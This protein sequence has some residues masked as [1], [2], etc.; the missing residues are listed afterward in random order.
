MERKRLSDSSLKPTILIES[1]SRFGATFLSTKYRDHALNGE[2][3]MDKITG[4]IF[5]KRATDGQIISFQQNK[6]LLNDIAFDFSILLMM[7]PS[8]SYPDARDSVEYN[9][10]SFY[11]STNYDLVTINNEKVFNL[12]NEDIIIPGGPTSYNKL[13]FDVSGKSNGFICKCSTRDC[14]KAF[15]EFITNQ[16]NKLVKDYSGV[17]EIYK[18][19]KSRY[20]DSDIWKVNNAVIVYDVIVYRGETPHEY[21]NKE[22][23]ITI[24]DDSLIMFDSDVYPVNDDTITKIT[25]TIKSIK[26]DKLRFMLNYKNDIDLFT[27][28]SNQ[29]DQAEIDRAKAE[30][31]AEQDMFNMI[32]NKLLPKDNN[33]SIGEF[34]I[35]Y[36]INDGSSIELFGNDNIVALLDVPHIR[37][38]IDKMT[39]LFGSRNAASVTVSNEQPAYAGLWFKPSIDTV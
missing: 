37:R 24:N 28:S 22:G 38:Y 18:A 11:I 36:F 23:S 31:E 26:F 32:Y 12:L 8:F 1:D 33:I 5:V 7:N 3:L 20:N 14:D 4:E 2:V 30:A 25:V 29:T 9:D 21:M 35:S 6:K 19:E 13:T 34:N 39:S 16:Y 10:S 27:D 15:I 17:N